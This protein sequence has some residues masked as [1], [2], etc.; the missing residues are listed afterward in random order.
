MSRSIVSGL[1]LGI[2]LACPFICS[3]GRAQQTTASVTGSVVDGSGAAINRAKVTVADKER[4]T[5]YTATTADS[6]VFTF[7]RIPI[8]TYDVKVEAPGFATAVQS[9]LTL[10]LNQTA[11]LDFKM[12]V[13]AVSNSVEVTSEAPALQSETTQVSTLIDA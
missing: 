4:G 9:G 7:A 5:L 12:T 1:T 3:P 6:G 13:G 8:G 2:L 11:R 10:V